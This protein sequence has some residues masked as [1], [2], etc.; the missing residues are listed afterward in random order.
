MFFENFYAVFVALGLLERTSAAS[1]YAAQLL[2]TVRAAK[3]GATVRTV[4]GRTEP[5]PPG[6]VRPEYSRRLVRTPSPE[7]IDTEATCTGR[8]QQNEPSEDTKV[9]VEIDFLGHAYG[10]LEL[11]IAV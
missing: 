6:F 11:P 4:I 1:L 2:T 5:F 9:L 3:T 10:T 8:E 7:A